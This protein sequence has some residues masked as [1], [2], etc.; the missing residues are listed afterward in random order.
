[1][2]QMINDY[3]RSCDMAKARIAELTQLRNKLKKQGRDEVINEL[4]LERRIRLLYVENSQME[5]IIDI[6]TSCLR[7]IEQRGKT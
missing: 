7:R 5:E 2:Q 3:K 6:L 4:D 1:M